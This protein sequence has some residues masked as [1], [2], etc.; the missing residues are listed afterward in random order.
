MP[1]RTPTFSDG[2]ADALLLGLE[3]KY[4]VP[5]FLVMAGSLLLFE[6]LHAAYP[7]LET[8]VTLCIVAVP[9]LVTLGLIRF[10]FMEHPKGYL[11]DYLLTKCFSFRA[12]LNPPQ[13]HE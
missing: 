3:F 4:V 12:T 8:T 6:V 5:L 7:E 2:G 11:W 10:F 1:E 13:D 9:P